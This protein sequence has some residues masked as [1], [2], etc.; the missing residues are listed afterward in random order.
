MITVRKVLY[1]KLVFWIEDVPMIQ[2]GPAR[3]I[4]KV[5]VDR[6][7]ADDIEKN[8]LATLCQSVISSLIK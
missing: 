6:E 7:C 4:Q 5:F 1:E 8:F 2:M 3:T